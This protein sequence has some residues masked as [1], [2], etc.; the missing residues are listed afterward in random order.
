MQ[1]LCKL[2]YRINEFF[3][4]KKKSNEISVPT[5]KFILKCIQEHLQKYSPN[6]FFVVVMFCFETRVVALG[7]SSA[8]DAEAV[9]PAAAA[10]KTSARTE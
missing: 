4:K 6:H 2:T 1:T 7:F 10:G 9:R 5:D 3:L 8:V